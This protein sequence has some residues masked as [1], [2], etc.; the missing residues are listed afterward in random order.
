MMR[1]KTILTVTVALLL[2]WPVAALSQAPLFFSGVVRWTTGNPAMGIEARL[3]QGGAV[4]ARAFTN[5][6]GLF[7]FYGLPGQPQAYTLEIY[8]GTRLLKNVPLQG[9]PVGGQVNIQL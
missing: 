3:V 6:A 7:G 8:Q 2:L 4:R 9:V 1:R 5:Q